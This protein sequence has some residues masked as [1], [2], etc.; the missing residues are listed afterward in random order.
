[1]V[2]VI[3]Y[4]LWSIHAATTG[5]QPYDEEIRRNPQLGSTL[6]S[7]GR[8]HKTVT[9]AVYGSLIAGS[10]LFQGLTAAYYFGRGKLLRAY[11]DQTPSWIVELQR[12][13]ILT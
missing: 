2:L 6:G 10:I 7:I 9:L 11:L 12:R 1:M 3:G 8:L 5:P 13:T 4:S